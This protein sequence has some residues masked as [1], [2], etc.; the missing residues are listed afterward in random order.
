MKIFIYHLRD[1]LSRSAYHKVA[2]EVSSDKIETLRPLTDKIKTKD[3]Y[4]KFIL[5]KT[6]KKIFLPDEDSVIREYSVLYNNTIFLKDHVIFF[7]DSEDFAK[8]FFGIKEITTV[9]DTLDN[10]T[11]QVFSLFL[12]G[13][14]VKEIS[15]RI[16]I[17]EV[18]I[19]KQIVAAKKQLND[20]LYENNSQR[21]K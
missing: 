20:L 3:K 21:I 13:Y 12:A 10:E 19:K 8:D 17:P 14:S 5:G 1:L 9:I 6:V 11:K 18:I 15:D 16:K 2:L 4:V 7:D